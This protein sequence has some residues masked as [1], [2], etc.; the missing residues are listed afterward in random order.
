MFYEKWIQS[1]ILLEVEFIDLLQPNH[2]IHIQNHANSDFQFF[3][4]SE[5][6]DFSG[7]SDSSDNSD[8]P[9]NSDFSDFSDNSDFSDD[10]DYIG[11]MDLC[12]DRVQEDIMDIA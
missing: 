11:H 9:D 1:L 4:F 3:Q 10:S 12:T 7:N 6:S 2:F 5:H 8:F